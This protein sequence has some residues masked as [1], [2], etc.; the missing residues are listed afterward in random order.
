MKTSTGISFL[1]KTFWYNSRSGY[2]L[3][4]SLVFIRYP[5]YVSCRIEIP[6]EFKLP[7][8]RR[9]N[10]NSELLILSKNS[11]S[12]LIKRKGTNSITEYS[13]TLVHSSGTKVSITALTFPLLQSRNHS[14]D[15]KLL[16]TEKNF[17]ELSLYLLRNSQEIEIFCY[18]KS[19][20]SSIYQLQDWK[21][22][23]NFN[24]Q[25]HLEC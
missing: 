8:V 14:Y 11:T 2:S 3:F 9:L 19:G 10:I 6:L 22:C 21:N 4:N 17:L 5:C 13:N 7:I 16:R 15:W 24:R 25:L 12:L 23:R 1:F 18:W 20:E